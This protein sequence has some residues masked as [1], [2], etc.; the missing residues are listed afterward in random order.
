M[1]Q[2]WRHLVL[3][4]PYLQ[5]KVDLRVAGLED[6]SSF[7]P[8]LSIAERHNQLRLHSAAWDRLQ[9]NSTEDFTIYYGPWEF[10]SGILVTSDGSGLDQFNLGLAPKDTRFKFKQP[11]SVYT[12]STERCWE[13]CLADIRVHDFIV[14]PSQDLLV[15]AEDLVRL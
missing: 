5:Y 10:L 1:S 4:S 6:N 8:D 12:H 14:D 15:A 7:R 11:P 9:W 2:Q 13:I 3:Q